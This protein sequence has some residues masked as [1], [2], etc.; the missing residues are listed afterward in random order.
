MRA[1]LE[2][3]AAPVGPGTPSLCGSLQN[4]APKATPG[5]LNTLTSPTPI[6]MINPAERSSSTVCSD[7]LQTSAEL[8]RQALLGAYQEGV[9]TLSQNTRAAVSVFAACAV[10][11][12]LPAERGL[13]LL[14]SVWASSF[15]KD[16]VKEHPQI[17]VLLD[18]VVTFYISEYYSIAEK[19]HRD[20]SEDMS[21]TR[22]HRTPGQVRPDAP[23][24]HL[25]EIRV[26]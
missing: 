5:C 17:R 16:L 25:S 24:N 22:G 19:I 13:I 23:S 21:E 15:N 14:K 11:N 10:R 2:T 8:L 20:G 26:S 3:L 1:Q 9:E 6:E 12:A 18:S 4:Q 7:E